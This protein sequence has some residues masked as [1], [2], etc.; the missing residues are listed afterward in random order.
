MSNVYKP[1]VGKLFEL[2]VVVSGTFWCC[3][4][5]HIV[6][7]SK[8]VGN[9][10]HDRFHDI[11]IYMVYIQLTI[12]HLTFSL[13]KLWTAHPRSM[14]MKDAKNVYV[15]ILCSITLNVRK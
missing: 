6:C 7:K 2:F 8:F 1:T 11:T 9:G 12:I 15:M 3:Y 4:P 14:I 13:S 10:F 5:L